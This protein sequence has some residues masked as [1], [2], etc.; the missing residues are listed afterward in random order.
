V[1]KKM[2]KPEHNQGSAPVPPETLNRGDGHY[3]GDDLLNDK[4]KLKKKMSDKMAGGKDR[5]RS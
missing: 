1:D 5:K 2:K 3:R 4:E